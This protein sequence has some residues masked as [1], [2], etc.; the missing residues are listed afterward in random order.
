MKYYTIPL[1]KYKELWIVQFSIVGNC[2]SALSR[3]RTAEDH[4]IHYKENIRSLV[5]NGMHC[6]QKSKWKV[7]AAGY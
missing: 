5:S 2:S 1:H 6:S 4:G 3:K 7:P